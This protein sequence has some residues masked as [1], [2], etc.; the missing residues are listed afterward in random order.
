[1][2]HKQK[3][4]RLYNAKFRECYKKW[5]LGLAFLYKSFTLSFLSKI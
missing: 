3:L 2:D 4:L 5:I 1:M